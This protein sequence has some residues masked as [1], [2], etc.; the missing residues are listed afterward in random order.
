[1]HGNYVSNKST[2]I[3]LAIMPSTV[4]AKE[5]AIKAIKQSTISSRVGMPIMP[6][7]ISARMWM[8]IMP[9]TEFARV[10]AW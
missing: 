10:F 9:S 1:M 4:S 8:A 2:R 5:Y 7:S 3:C 6:P